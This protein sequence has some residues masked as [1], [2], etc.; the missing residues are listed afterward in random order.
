LLNH[1]SSQYEYEIQEYLKTFGIELQNRN[2]SVLKNKEIDLFSID[3]NIGIE[4]NGD[5]WHSELKVSNNYQKEKS[6]LAEQNNIKLLHIWENEWKNNKDKLKQYLYNQFGLNKNTVYARECE[7]REVDYIEKADFLN[8]YHLQDNTNSGYNI[9]LYYKDELVS[10]MCFKQFFMNKKYEWDLCRFCNKFDTNI[11]G[12]ASK[13]FKYFLKEKQPKSVVSYQD[14]AKFGGNLYSTLGFKLDHITAPN[15]K[16]SNRVQS[17]PKTQCRQKALKMLGYIKG[18]E[19][20]IMHSLNY[21]KVYD[22]G[23][24]VWVY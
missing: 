4:F 14:I 6:I 20:D 2:R 9:G 10:V 5:Y 1:S 16:W 22:C 7:I 24:K 8:R 13:L 17:I 15:Y 11:V 18:S 21:F 23:L 19:S 3:K 12:G